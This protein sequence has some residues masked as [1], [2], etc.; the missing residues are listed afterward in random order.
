MK[1]AASNLLFLAHIICAL[2][3]VAAIVFLNFSLIRFWFEGEFSQNMGSIEISYIQMAKFWAEGGSLWR[4]W[5]YLGHPWHVFYTPLLPFLE[6][7]LFE[8]F[9]VSFGHA[10]RLITGI[11]YVLVPV[12]TFLFVWQIAKSKTGAFVSALFYSFVPSVIAFLFREVAADSLS[13]GFEPRRFAIL[14]RWGE[15]PHTLALV[16]VPL[17]G[18]FLAR[19]LEKGSTL[20][21]FAASLFLGFS[22]LTNAISVWV[23]FLMVIAM[24]L[25]ALGRDKAEFI[26]LFKSV[27]LV[28]VVSWGLVA[29]WYNWPFMTTFFK[30]GGS[31]VSNWLS[32]KVWGLVMFAVGFAGLFLLVKKVTHKLEG[33]TFALL[34]FLMLFAIVYFYYASG[35]DQLEF[36][37][38]ALRLNTEV[39]LAL[40]V[41]V[42]VVVS[43]AYLMFGKLM[44]KVKPA[45][46]LIGLV[47][48]LVI[49]IIILNFGQKLITTMPEHTRDISASITKSP[50]NTPEFRVSQKLADLTKDTDERVFVPG[51]Y[52]F[53]LNY[54]VPVAQ[55]RGALFQSS[56]NSWP[57]HLYY[58]ITN[59]ADAQISLAWLKIANVGKFVYT[60]PGSGEIYKDFK[61]P[62][63]KFDGILKDPIAEAGDVYFD[64]PLLNN[65]LAKIIDYDKILKIKRPRNAI[66][67]EPIF[68]YVSAIEQYSDTRVNAERLSESHWRLSGEVQKG[69]GIVFQQT[70]DSGWT[71]KARSGDVRAWSKK[72]DAFDYLVLIPKGEGPFEV[73]LVYTRPWTVIFGYLVTLVTFGWLISR[74]LRKKTV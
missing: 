33:L 73:D 50:Q 59:G 71:T 42:G 40:S 53:W 57:E 25:A 62:Q 46:E 44:T 12:S 61:V 10:Y 14:V 55:V 1:S 29:F 47:P 60:G 67:E 41:L 54:F 74:G 34:W 5:W 15:G 39:D 35:E 72:K 70:F 49:C 31:A 26:S 2:A 18:L 23:I 69:Q 37:P 22:V 43:G 21:L 6:L 32:L 17:S 24:V 36:A 52:S 3:C 19:Y 63:S 7:G 48:A 4:Q 20:N 66:D 16:F 51:N 38:Q 68:A 58:Q 8:L 30:E 11:G 9:N 56:T 13:G 45:G 65:N 64:V 27:L 28:F